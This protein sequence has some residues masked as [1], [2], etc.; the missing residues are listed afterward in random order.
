MSE[1]ENEKKEVLVVLA[2][3]DG[4]EPDPARINLL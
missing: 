2:H 4:R 3:E 1:R